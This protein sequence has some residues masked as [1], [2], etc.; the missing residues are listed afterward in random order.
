MK[1]AIKILLFV[2]LAGVFLYSAWQLGSYYL[3]A[4]R[5][6]QTVSDLR[7]QLDEGGD[8]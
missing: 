1:K 8:P 4:F 7:G 2:V 5:Q 6:E 3:T